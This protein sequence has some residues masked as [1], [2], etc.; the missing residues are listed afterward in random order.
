MGPRV[1]NVP[2]SRIDEEGD[3]V[4]RQM[5]APDE[6]KLA[7][8][9]YVARHAH[10]WGAFSFH[11]YRYTDPQ[12]GAWV[13]RVAELLAS[14]TAVAQCRERY[15]SPDELNTVRRQAAEEW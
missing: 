2:A 1:S 8:E 11:L 3:W 4:V 6:L 10:E 13:R 12:L 15:L 5:I 7:P 14:E 9:E